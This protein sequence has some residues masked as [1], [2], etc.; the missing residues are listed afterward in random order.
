MS[1]DTLWG[2]WVWVCPECDH[3]HFVPVHSSPVMYHRGQEP[4]RPE[5][6]AAKVPCCGRI[7]EITPANI[8]WVPVENYSPARSTAA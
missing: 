3:S 1:D 7:H 6:E 2:C 5:F 8:Q 4:R